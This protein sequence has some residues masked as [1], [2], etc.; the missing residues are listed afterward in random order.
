MRDGD[1][2]GLDGAHTLDVHSHYER[3]LA[4]YALSGDENARPGDIGLESLAVAE[5]LVILERAVIQAD[6]HELQETLHMPLLQRLTIAE[7]SAL[8]RGLQ[9]GSADWAVNLRAEL[10]AIKRELD[11]SQAA[12]MRDDAVLDL[13]GA[14]TV[15]PADCTFNQVLLTGATGFLGP[16]LL[17]SLLDQTSATYTVLMRGTDPFGGTRT[18]DS[19][20]R[21]GGPL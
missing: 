17:R 7:I 16:F 4:A 20:S 8:V 6:A 14:G 13:P 10:D 3:F 12:E 11:E 9:E 5:L 15:P 2:A 21:G 18:A 1:A 19:C